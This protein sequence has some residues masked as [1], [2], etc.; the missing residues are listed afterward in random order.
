[1]TGIF[2][3]DAGR[4]PKDANELVYFTNLI[5]NV[6]FKKFRDTFQEKNIKTREQ[7]KKNKIAS[8]MYKFIEYIKNYYKNLSQIL[9]ILKST[10]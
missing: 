1:M 7:F 3:G 2:F 8:T 5:N 9:E 4:F 10:I 6:D